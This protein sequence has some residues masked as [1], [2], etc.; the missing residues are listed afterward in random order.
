MRACAVGLASGVLV[1]LGLLAVPSPAVAHA[2]LL[3]STPEDGEVVEALPDRVAL[4]FTETM[5]Q[6]AY[7]IV[8]SPDGDQVTV[9]D[10]EVHGAVVSQA[11]ADEGG[12]GTYSVAYR[13][14]SED[15]HPLTGE[16]RFSVGETAGTPAGPAAAS[17]SESASAGPGG[18]ASTAP[19]GDDANGVAGGRLD[20]AVPVALFALALVL[21]AMSRRQQS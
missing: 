20:V 2:T 21:L 5:A 16:V 3:T 13:A 9:G 11:L 15:G 6:P 19:R 14:V 7:V 4:E 1:L 17:G 10:P 18:S 12:P 8:R